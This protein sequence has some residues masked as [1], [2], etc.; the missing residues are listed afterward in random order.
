MRR[1]TSTREIEERCKKAKVTCLDIQSRSQDT[2]SIRKIKEN[3]EMTQRIIIDHSYQ[4]AYL[5]H[6]H[7]KAASQYIE[8]ILTGMM[9]IPPITVYRRED[10]I[11]EILDGQ[12]RLITFLSFIDGKFPSGEVFKLTGLEILPELNG[13]TF[14]QLTE[15]FQQDILSYNIDIEIIEGDEKVKHTVFQ[16]RNSNA[17]PLTVD[18]KRRNTYHGEFMNM[19]SDMRNFIIENNFFNNQSLKRHKENGILHS[20][21][22]LREAW[23]FGDHHNYMSNYLKKSRVRDG[24][25]QR[26]QHDSSMKVKEQKKMLKKAFFN[27]HYL[28]GRRVFYYNYGLKSNGN[29]KFPLFDMSMLLGSLVPSSR[30]GAMILTTKNKE[31]LQQE[32]IRFFNREDVLVLIIRPQDFLK[33][34]LQ[35]NLTTKFMNH[36]VPLLSSMG[37]E[38]IDPKRVLTVKEKEEIVIDRNDLCPLCN[39]PLGDAELELHHKTAHSKGGQTSVDNMVW[40]HKHCNRRLGNGQVS[41]EEDENFLVDD[42]IND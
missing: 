36:F 37:V 42:G 15:D 39:K 26:H 40:V 5:L 41:M 33:P 17:I 18:E 23:V 2:M 24:Y 3:I 16:I 21:L 14:L 20:F 6:G 19:I 27:A 1:R 10:G 32:F 38:L 12:Q 25:A 31:L 30:D 28:F 9:N 13:L 11:R 29:F 8:T 22:A 7:I 34:T 35:R 4:R